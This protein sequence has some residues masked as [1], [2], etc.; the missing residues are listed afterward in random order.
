MFMSDVLKIPLEE[1]NKRERGI[2]T[3]KQLTPCVC[4]E[5]RH[6]LTSIRYFIIDLEARVLAACSKAFI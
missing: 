5:E 3:L 6:G 2:C 1:L 4:K